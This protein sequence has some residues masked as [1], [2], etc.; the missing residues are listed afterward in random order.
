MAGTRGGNESR[1]QYLSANATKSAN[2]RPMRGL[3]TASSFPIGGRD[4]PEDG[5]EVGECLRAR[6][7]HRP[8]PGRDGREA[9]G[10]GH[11]G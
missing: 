1:C 9:C 7:R 10:G 3:V 8:L 2:E 11:C 6:G 4:G 5:G